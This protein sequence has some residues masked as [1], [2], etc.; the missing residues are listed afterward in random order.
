MLKK[1]SLLPFALLLLIQFSTC[2]PNRSS[3]EESDEDNSRE[4]RVPESRKRIEALVY[5]DYLNFLNYR[6]E[7][8]H[9]IAKDVL[10]DPL[11]NSIN[12]PA[13]EE[14]KNVLKKYVK[15]SK[16]ALTIALPADKNDQQNRF[17]F[18]LGKDFVLENFNRFNR[19]RASTTEKLTLEQKVSWEAMKKHGILEYNRELELRTNEFVYSIVDGFDNYIKTLTPAE[20][21][22]E[23]ELVAVWNRY[24]KK[25]VGMD[26][27]EF[28]QRL[29]TIFFQYETKA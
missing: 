29:F 15:E 20:R 19:T 4:N 18:A 9:K 7:R 26:K 10:A 27:I 2:M 1:L 16:E 23:Q 12:S 5:K 13:M 14:E 24:N 25:E 22:K 3:A 28:G 17:F 21:E 8:S 6:L 11:M